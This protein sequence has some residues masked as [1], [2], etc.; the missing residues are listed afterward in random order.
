MSFLSELRVD[1]GRHPQDRRL[2]ETTSGSTDEYL[3]STMAPEYPVLTQGRKVKRL[4]DRCGAF[5]AG[6]HLPPNV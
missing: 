2:F 3:W 4:C 5:R 6:R 1:E